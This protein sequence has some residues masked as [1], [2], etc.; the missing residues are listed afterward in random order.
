MNEKTKEL[1]ATSENEFLRNLGSNPKMNVIY[2]APTLV[3]VSGKKDALEPKTDCS[4]A[5]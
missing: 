2:N 5:I 4:A 1:M 3:I